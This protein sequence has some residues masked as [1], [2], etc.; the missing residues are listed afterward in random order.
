VWGTEGNDS[1]AANRFFG[2]IGKSR[3]HAI[4]VISPDMGS[5]YAKSARAHAPQATA[6][7]DPFH[8]VALSNRALDEVRRAYWNE[9]RRLGDQATARRFKD[10]R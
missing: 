5:G 3:S 9:L 8:V 1:A 10:A 7:I 2:Q 4:E 6:A